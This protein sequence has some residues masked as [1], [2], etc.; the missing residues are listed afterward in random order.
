MTSKA[1]V[2]EADVFLNSIFGGI[3]PKTDHIL[4][5]GVYCWGKERMFTSAWPPFL[6]VCKCNKKCHRTSSWASISTLTDSQRPLQNDSVHFRQQSHHGHC[7][8]HHITRYLKRWVHS[9]FT[10]ITR[11]LIVIAE[12]RLALS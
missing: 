9:S 11:I 8:Q 2:R 6:L 3:Y 7:P 12:T 1:A 5:D 10:T 4:F